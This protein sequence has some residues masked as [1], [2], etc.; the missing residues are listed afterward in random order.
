MSK[1]SRLADRS[2]D[3]LGLDEETREAVRELQ[4]EWDR[5]N[6]ERV[7]EMA[8]AINRQA[9]A[10]ERIQNTLSVL[11]DLLKPTILANQEGKFPVAFNTLSDGQ[12]PDLATAQLVADPIALGF[13]LSQADLARAL[14]LTAATTSVLVRVLG[15]DQLEECA[16]VV[17]QGKKTKIV[18]YSRLA[19]DK[20]RYLILHA[21]HD[22]LS[23]EAKAALGR[24][25]GQFGVAPGAD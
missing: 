24:A 15:L 2:F 10:I 23:Q 16:V 12:P 18:N 25:C 3:N 5:L 11:V 1:V 8:Q 9:A 17:R 7:A 19:V 21:D 4:L 20:L 22:S 13:T 6:A 14:K